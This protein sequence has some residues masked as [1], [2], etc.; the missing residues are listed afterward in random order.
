MATMDQLT[1][2]IQILTQQLASQEAKLQQVEITKFRLTPDQII[3]NF[4]D[5]TSFS[6]E[7][8]FKLKSFL[9]DV[10]CAEQ[11]CGMDNAELKTYCLNKIIN[12]KI[13]G[14]ARNCILEIPEDER[15]WQTVVRTLTLRFRPKQTIYNLTFLAKELK[16]FNLK[17]LFNKLTK[18]KADA[19]EICDFNG[20]E[21]FVY[22]AIDKEL[23]QILKSKLIP[24]VQFQVDE[25][26]TLFELDNIMCQSE[27]YYSEDIIKPSSKMTKQTYKNEKDFKN[28]RINNVNSN[29]NHNHYQNRHNSNFKSSYNQNN[30]YSREQNF[31][32][33]QSN[34][35]NNS[36]PYRSYD[37]NNHYNNYTN[38]NNYNNQNRGQNGSRQS[39]FHNQNNRTEP[40]EVD[41]INT[42][43]QIGEEVNFTD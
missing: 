37:N 12:G 7:D 28:N 42:G 15:N 41:N 2:Q 31:Y 26:K 6:G 36:R 11:L 23:V 20:E 3:R 34:S 30:N 33:R 39:R 13:I 43:S 17:E 10:N 24:I 19:N 1:Q 29:G 25:N 5:I 38:N 21:E 8:S 16:V 35:N 14:K 4:N 22:R 27:M 18:I 32:N 40:M 9:K